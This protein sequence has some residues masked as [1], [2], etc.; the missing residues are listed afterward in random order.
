MVIVILLFVVAILW[1]AFLLK[2]LKKY[3]DNMAKM[4]ENYGGKQ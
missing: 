1:I 2:V 3:T 4:G